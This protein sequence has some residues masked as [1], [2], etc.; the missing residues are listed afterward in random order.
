MFCTFAADRSRGFAETI[1]AIAAGLSCGV[2]GGLGVTARLVAGSSVRVLLVTIVV[3]AAVYLAASWP[4][5]HRL[6]L[7]ALVAHRAPV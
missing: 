5:R 1:H 3:T 4:L 2:V 7:V 6:G